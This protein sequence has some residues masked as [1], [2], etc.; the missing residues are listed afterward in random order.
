MTI[1]ARTE[2]GHAKAYSPQSKLPFK[3][4]A[5]LKVVDGRTS[6]AV[7]EDSL[8][9]FGDVHGLLESLV[10]SGLIKTLSELA[11]RVRATEDPTNTE[12]LAGNLHPHNACQWSATRVGFAESSQ[13]PTLTMH[14]WMGPATVAMPVKAHPS[15][16]G[17]LQALA[18]AV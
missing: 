2:E 16:V 4:R 9:A 7:F 6:L 15:D 3:L 18:Q 5:R 10:I 12:Q 1:H 8:R 11:N 14:S 17:E 13:Q